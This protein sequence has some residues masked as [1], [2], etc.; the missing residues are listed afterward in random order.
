[1]LTIASLIRPGWILRMPHDAYGPGIEVVK[2][3]R[4]Q[5][6]RPAAGAAARGPPARAGQA[7]H[8]ARGGA[9]GARPPRPHRPPDPATQA[10]PARRRRPRPRPP[11]PAAKSPP[12]RP[13]PR[14]GQDAGRVG[15]GA[16]RGPA[17]APPPARPRPR[18]PPPT[19]ATSPRPGPRPASP[20]QATA[21]PVSARA[22]PRRA[23]RPRLPARTRRR[24]AARRRR[25]GRSGTPPPQAGAAPPARPAGG[26]PR[27]GRRLGRA[28]AAPG[29]GRGR[30]A[31]ARR[32]P[33][34][35][36]PRAARPGPDAAD[37]VRRAHRR[38]QPGPVGHPAQPGRARPLVRGRA[39]ARCGGCRWPTCLASIGTR[40]SGTGPVPGAGVD[41][42]RCHRPGP[43][44]PRG[45][46][47]PD[48]RPGPGELVADALCAMATEIATS[49][50]VRR[51]A[52]DPGGGRGRPGGARARTGCTWRTPLAEALPLLEAH[53]AEVADALAASGAAVGAGRPGRGAASRRPGC[54]TTWSR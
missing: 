37:R 5:A 47:R 1:M 35:P 39:T 29:R 25:T 45:R 23:A 13:P 46:A 36:V 16:R 44:G 17:K 18:L 9:A 14:R 12:Q 32:G 50:L 43:G 34:L 4:G 3:G 15:P 11:R 10:P 7:R 48:R 19:P 33:A 53:A 54:R 42:H 8:R 27:A 24:R 38:R 2:A 21:G 30:R 40:L 28:G 51:A 26:P 52:P 20:R 6:F 41:R 22:R 49:L 31:N